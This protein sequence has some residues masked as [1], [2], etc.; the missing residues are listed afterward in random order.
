G[1]AASIAASQEL[2]CLPATFLVITQARL[3]QRDCLVCILR[4]R[5]GIA[6]LEDEVAQ[7]VVTDPGQL[8]ALVGVAEYLREGAVQASLESLPLGSLGGRFLAE[9]GQRL[10]RKQNG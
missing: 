2:P 9:S 4:S 7:G 6:V 10:G 3:D 1:L 5:G 8:G